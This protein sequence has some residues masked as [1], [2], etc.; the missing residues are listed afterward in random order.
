MAGLTKRQKC[1]YHPQVSQVS[2]SFSSQFTRLCHDFSWMTSP[3]R[4]LGFV[5]ATRQSTK[6][7]NARESALFCS[8]VSVAKAFNAVVSAADSG[9]GTSI[10]ITINYRVIEERMHKGTY[11]VSPQHRPPS[12]PG[13]LLL[14]VRHYHLPPSSKQSHA[15]EQ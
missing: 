5:C 15:D 11:Q 7:S 4:T 12:I 1:L 14:P 6:P 2:H 9:T 13:H 8:L 3:A 10:R